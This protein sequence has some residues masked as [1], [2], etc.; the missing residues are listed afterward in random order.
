MFD[1][2]SIRDGPDQ[3]IQYNSWRPLITPETAVKAVA[4]NRVGWVNHELYLILDVFSKQ[5][6][7]G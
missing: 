3:A 1:E 6:P 2:L 4:L 5:R 7:N